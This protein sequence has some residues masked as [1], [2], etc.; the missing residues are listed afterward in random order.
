MMLSLMYGVTGVQ[1]PVHVEIGGGI[2]KREWN[3]DELLARI[4]YAS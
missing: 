3:R 1:S 2:R 4:I